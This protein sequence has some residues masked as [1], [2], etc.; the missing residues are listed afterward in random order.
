M[1]QSE[2]W[3]TTL[4]ALDA[5][6]RYEVRCPDGRTRIVWGATRQTGALFVTDWPGDVWMDCSDGTLRAEF[7]AT[8][9]T[10]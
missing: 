4:A 2:P 6:A 1:T 5:G 8:P 3:Q 7:V 9:A 10:P